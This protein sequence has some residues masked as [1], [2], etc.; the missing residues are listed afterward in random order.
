[1]FKDYGGTAAKSSFIPLRGAGMSTTIEQAIARIP[2]WGRASSLTV[3]PLSGG[4]T[5]FNYRVDVDGEAFVVRIAARD[6]E[7]LGIDRQREY[8]CA[9]AASRAGVAPEVVHFLP[10]EGIMVTRFVPGRPL[11]RAEMAQP[12]VMGRVVQS[13][14]RYHSGAAFEGSFSPF[15]TI[16]EYLGVAR[17]KGAPLPHDIDR[18]H[19]GTGEIEAALRRAQTTIRPCHNDL[20]GPNLIDDGGQV[21]IVDWEY[22]GM[23]DIYF[24]L[25]NYAMHCE[26]SDVQAEALLR[27]YF[28]EVPDSGLA[29]VRLLRIV[30]DLRDA[31]WYMVGLHVV[32]DTTDFVRYAATHFKRCRQA[33]SDS[34]LSLWLDAAAR[35]A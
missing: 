22:A 33:I 16:E 10:D 17:L 20:W 34:R 30:A 29:R 8:R 21:R 11:S 19:T 28:G 12:D 9:L 18:M 6:A 26:A 7:L 27:T 32:S 35:G 2:S 15:K 1:M 14:R 31:L 5:N 25:A 24:D 23:G 4:I 13:M 3:T